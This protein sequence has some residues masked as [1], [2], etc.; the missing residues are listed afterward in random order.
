LYNESE[1]SASQFLL[2]LEDLSGCSFTQQHIFLTEAHTLAGL[3]FLAGLHSTFWGKSTLA[4]T[5][6]C[7]LS[8]LW[9]KATYWTLE[10]RPADEL[11]VLPTVWAEF[12]GAFSEASDI[13][14]QERILQLGK[15]LVQKSTWV[16][17]TMRHLSVP[18][19]LVHGD[20]KSANIFFREDP[21]TKEIKE[22][23]VIDFQWSGK[24]YGICDVMY[25][26]L[27]AYNLGLWQNNFA[28]EKKLIAYYCER[29]AVH[30]VQYSIENAIKDF[31]VAALDFSRVVLAYF[32]ARYTPQF[33]EIAIKDAGE[34]THTSS[35]PHIIDLLLY[36]DLLLSQLETHNEF[37]I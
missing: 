27:G 26:V 35:L 37:T 3:D 4:N 18:F 13:F 9:D 20:F 36:L 10:K 21:T 19:T 15:R 23:A 25:L 28:L 31:R 11:D 24:G 16:T 32:F 34:L 8:L 7:N 6:D 30:G 12:C 5:G 14:K 33:L 2:L 1:L 29:L 22:V 17:E